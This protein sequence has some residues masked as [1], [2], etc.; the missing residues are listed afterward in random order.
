MAA[1]LRAGNLNTMEVNSN[2]TAEIGDDE[3]YVPI[4]GKV[5]SKY[6]DDDSK[7]YVRLKSEDNEYTYEAFPVPIDVTSKNEGYDYGMYLDT[8]QVEA[9]TYDIDVITQKDNQY[10]SSGVVSSLEL[11]E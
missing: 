6:I 3:E 10:Y 5:D 4:S 8:S 11:E 9:G 2:T 1:P 7:I